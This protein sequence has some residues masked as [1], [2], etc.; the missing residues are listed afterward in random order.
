MVEW[1]RRSDVK[2]KTID[3]KEIAEDLVQDTFVSAL[4]SLKGFK[5]NSSEKTWMTTILKNK[6]IDYLRMLH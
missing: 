3:K 6:I 1:F 2:I 5:G 4:N